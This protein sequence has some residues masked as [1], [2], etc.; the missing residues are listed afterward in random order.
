MAPDMTNFGYKVLM[1]NLWFSFPMKAVIASDQF[2]APSVRTTTAVT[3]VSGGTKANVLPTQAVATV[4][5]RI[6][7]GDSVAT[8]LE[9]DA[10]II[11]DP[12]VQLRKREG[13][14]EPSPVSS[15]ESDAFGIV[16]VSVKQSFGNSLVVPAVMIANTDSR[17]YW[18][19]AE[20]IYRFCPT[21][22]RKSEL[23][24]FHGINE[25]IAIDNYVSMIEFYYRLIRNAQDP[26]ATVKASSVGRA[27][28][29]L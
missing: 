27:K 18:D 15:C 12:R 8:V 14:L 5:H 17:H 23:S 29:D 21:V 10:A 7:P 4:N 19:V 1:S 2:M 13:W 24:M 6:V 25:R 28:E 16:E 20:D 3:I 9:R 26:A 22:L 11:N